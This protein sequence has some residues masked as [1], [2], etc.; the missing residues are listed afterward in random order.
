VILKVLTGK[1]MKT[2]QQ[3]RH[4]ITIDKDGWVSHEDDNGDTFGYG[5][6]GVDVEIV[7]ERDVFERWV[8]PVQQERARIIEEVEKCV[9]R[10]I[11]YT[12]W[13][14]TIGSHSDDRG[15]ESDYPCDCRKDEIRYQTEA[16]KD[17]QKDIIKIIKGK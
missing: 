4:I 1:D 6:I 16:Y 9:E 3:P 11:K 8:D 15:G 7:D 14:H 2:K 5:D 10:L 17:I 13:K 12:D